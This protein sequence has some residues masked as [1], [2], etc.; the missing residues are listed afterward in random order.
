MDQV[1]TLPIRRQRHHPHEIDLTD[2][3]V[4]PF[5]PELPLR[6]RRNSQRP[7]FDDEVPCPAAIRTQSRLQRASEL[8]AAFLAHAD[9]GIDWGRS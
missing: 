4:N 8:S 6:S 1:A 3:F 2:V 7:P 5:R 9:Q